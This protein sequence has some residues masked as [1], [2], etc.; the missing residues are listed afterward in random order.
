M[1]RPLAPS[2]LLGRYSRDAHVRAREIEAEPLP[3]NVAVLLSEAA[4]EVPERTALHFFE[5]GEVVTYADLQDLVRRAATGLARIGVEKGSHVGVML[6]NILAFPVAWLALAQLG[7]VMVPINLQYTKREF[8]QVV[9]DADID[10]LVID[11]RCVDLLAQDEVGKAHFP[12]SRIVVRGAAGPGRHTWDSLAASFA[13]APIESAAVELD[14]PLNIQYT[15]GTTGM[16]KGCLLTHRYWLVQG[17]G[18][19]TRDGVRYERILAS[20]PFY[21]MDPQWLVLM[22]FYQRATLYVASRQSTSRYASLLKDR[23][24]HFS[25][26]PAEAMLKEPPNPHDGDNEVRRVNVYGL[27]REAHAEVE[28]RYCVNAREA[29]GM[30]ELGS[31]LSIP[32]DADE[33]TGSGSCGIHVPFRECRIVDDEGRD[34]PSGEIGELVVR[35]PGIFHGYYGNLEATRQA[36]FGEWFRTGDLFRCDERGYF[37][38]VGRLKEMIRRSSENIPA[39]EVELVL[40][41][42]PEIVEAA[43]L[44]VPDP[45]RKEEVKVYVI[46]RPG[47]TLSD[48]PPEAIIEHARR[49]LAPFKIPRYVEYRTEFPRTASGKVRKPMLAAE[50]ADLRTDSWDRVDGTWR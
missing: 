13:E 16:P 24:I 28:R 9:G 23:G 40:R 34:V 10:F 3:A 30:T 2:M 22:A 25:L 17:K 35:G 29:Y 15:S 49:S 33:M 43:A 7:A 19:A 8:D 14:D 46:L 48:V 5:A 31:A 38:L 4:A 26:M 6:P 39:R 44:P 45:V 18:N 12:D 36:F 27:R 32:L 42:M 50:K 20:T 47:L 1:Q 21:Y 37:Y 41:A 11:E